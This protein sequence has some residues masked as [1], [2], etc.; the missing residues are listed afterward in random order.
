MTFTAAW[1]KDAA[2]RV[3]RAFLVAFV[4]QLVLAGANVFNQSTLHAAEAA[5]LASCLSVLL[6]VLGAAKDGTVS[7]A[8]LAP[9]RPRRRAHKQAGLTAI[10]VIGAVCVAAVALAL[11]G[12]GHPWFLLLLILA[13][14]CLA[15]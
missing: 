3:V 14:V 11:L 6:S 10:G 1:L 12:A 4:G 5:G 15:L 9:A 2:E 8:S 13:A 7:P